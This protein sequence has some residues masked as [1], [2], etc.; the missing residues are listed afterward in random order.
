MT[1]TAPAVG[2]IAPADLE[3]FVRAAGV[4]AGL[5]EPAAA[6]LAEPLVLA[7]MMGVHTH[8]TK[9]L[10]GYLRK[11]LGGGYPPQ[12]EPRVVREGPAWAVVDGAATLGQIGCTMGMRL[13]IEKAKQVGV[14]S[15]AV[16]NTGH[17]GAAGYYAVLAARA[18][19]LGIVA[20]NDYP[21]V[22]APGA[23]MAVLGSNPLA[24]AAPQPDGDPLLFDISTAAVAGGKVYAAV[25]RGEPI[26][27]DWL[28]G[29]DGLPTTDGRLYPAQAALAPMAGHKGY[30]FA[31]LAEL[32]SGVLGGG[33]VVTQI[34]DWMRD[35]PDVAS[36]HCAGFVVLDLEAI[37]D[38]EEYAA[39]MRSLVR[40][41]REAPTAAG[42]ERVLLPGERE[43]GRERA[44]RAVG[45]RLPDDVR[46][47]LHAAAILVGLE[48]PG[49]SPTSSEHAV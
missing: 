3:A 14:A 48:S 2:T 10:P 6:M 16:R 40:E 37:C 32:L 39:A 7:D 42:V 44:A 30:G 28:I 5:A 27:Q 36:R 20:G 45:I 31:L 19:C 38:R 1:P 41:I 22:A 33:C 46:E 18:G 25:A 17:I 13:A 12:G 35:P 49:V 4:R 43:W 15:V 21:S 47:K 8:G 9:L 24:W 11:L 29:R 34:G 26:P 23:R